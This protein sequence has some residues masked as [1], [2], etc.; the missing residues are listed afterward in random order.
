[1]NG[2]LVRSRTLCLLLLAGSILPAFRAGAQTRPSPAQRVL[3]ATKEMT[4]GYE[5]E[6]VVGGCWDFVNAV[7][8]R[9]GFPPAARKNVF[10]GEK[11]GP[12]A[13]NSRILPGDWLYLTNSGRQWE[14]SAIFVRWLGEGVAEVYQYNGD[15]R[16]E[17]GFLGS[18][19]VTDVW[20]IIRPME[21]NSWVPLP[22]SGR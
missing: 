2:V 6:Y 4:R 11:N 12:Y 9:A 17:A 8:Y 22:E 15:R 1:M 13:D 19:E 10:R 7:F 18:V 16:A 21:E 3:A 20:A 14:H 5:R